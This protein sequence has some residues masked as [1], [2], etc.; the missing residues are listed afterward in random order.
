MNDS[1]DKEAFIHVESEYK[2]G[3]TFWFYID[4]V[5]EDKYLEIGHTGKDPSTK[6]EIPIEETDVVFDTI[7]NSPKLPY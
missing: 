6:L 3:S 4:A 1:E 5:E 2:T 7:A